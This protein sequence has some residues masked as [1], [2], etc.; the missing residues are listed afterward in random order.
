VPWARPRSRASR[1]TW[2]PWPRTMPASER[3]HATCRRTVLG[4]TSW[5]TLH[6]HGRCRGRRVRERRQ[7][8]PLVTVRFGPRRNSLW[9]SWSARADRG[10]GGRTRARRG[11]GPSHAATT[12]TKFVD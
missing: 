11:R 4:F 6:V 1:R 5:F 12:V 2:K 8:P 7:R 3:N 10:S 9:A